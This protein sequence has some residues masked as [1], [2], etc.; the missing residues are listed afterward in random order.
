MLD[1]RIETG[2]LRD[3]VKL[4]TRVPRGQSAQV[5]RDVK[6]ERVLSAAL[7]L[8]ILCMRSE[9]LQCSRR[10]KRDLRLPLPYK[11]FDLTGAATQRTDRLRLHV[12]EVNEHHV[13][14]Q[15]RS[16]PSATLA[17]TLTRRSASAPPPARSDRVPSSGYDL[18]R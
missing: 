2:V 9:P 15:V 10:R 16:S 14:L 17:L 13:R 6:V 11:H 5:E 1:E 7:D 4:S 18:A 12:L 3:H 8:H